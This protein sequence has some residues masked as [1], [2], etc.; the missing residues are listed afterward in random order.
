MILSAVYLL[1]AVALPG[2]GGSAAP[3]DPDDPPIVFDFDFSNGAPGWLGG[4]A[5][6]PVA[7]E[8]NMMIDTGARALPAPLTGDGFYLYGKNLSDALFLYTKR[9]VTGLKPNTAYSVTFSA[10]FATKALQVGGDSMFVHAGVSASEPNR[11]VVT[12]SGQPYYMMN[13]ELQGNGV[14]NP[15]NTVILGNLVKPNPQSPDYEIKTVTDTRAVIGRSGANGEAWILVGVQ[16]GFEVDTEVY[17]TRV[18][19]TFRP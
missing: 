6:Y 14:T 13:I 2:C 5:Q 9:R 16:S 15:A 19:A 1:F 3:P 12:V 7:Y 10:S 18:R 17:F 11:I 8:P 4:S